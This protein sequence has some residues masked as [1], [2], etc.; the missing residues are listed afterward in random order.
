MKTLVICLAALTLLSATEPIMSQTTRKELK[1]EL[2]DKAIRKARVE[3]KK[4]KKEGFYV[5][6][7]ALPMDKQIE[8]AWMREVEVNEEGYPM[9]IIATGTAVAESQI[10]ARLQ[11]TEAAKMELAGTIATEVAALVE[12]NI[13]N[14]QLSTED[15]ASVTKTVAAAKNIIA[16]ELGRVIPLFEIYRTYGKTVEVDL[17]IAYDSKLAL[18]KA[19]TAIR[20]KLE[21]ETQIM[22]DQLNKLLSID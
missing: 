19:K 10:A 14:Q 16:Q 17:R 6:P 8:R 13:A 3:S 15:A 2:K 20:A 5:A 4:F 7:G 18:D 1:K 9:Y 12:N 21:A 11:A 22:Q